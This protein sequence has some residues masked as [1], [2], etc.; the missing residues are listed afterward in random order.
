MKKKQWFTLIEILIVI[1]LVSILLIGF[2]RINLNR[3]SWKQKLDIETQKIVNIFEEV[4]NNALTWKA[5]GVNL[6]YPE[7]WWINLSWSV[8]SYYNTGVWNNE[9]YS[10]WDP[11]LNTSISSVRC[12]DLNESSTAIAG[13]ITLSFSWSQ[14]SI[15]SDCGLWN[16]EKIIKFTLSRPPFENTIE[17]HSISGIIKVD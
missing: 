9:V 13:D 4:K 11:P 2:S 15:S 6:D 17:F 8:V 5:V 16:P 3:L 1:T 12:Y 14:N 10:S 7:Y